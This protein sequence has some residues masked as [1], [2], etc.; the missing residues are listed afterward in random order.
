MPPE[1]Q[2]DKLVRKK[3]SQGVTPGE[4]R[5]EIKARA[6]TQKK[7][8]KSE[9]AQAQQRALAHACSFKSAPYEHE[10]EGAVSA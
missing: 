3:G 8:Q 1:R 6:A 9:R 5:D 4:S 7:E 10:A 2:K